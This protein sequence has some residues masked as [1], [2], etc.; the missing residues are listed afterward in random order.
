MTIK[1]HNKRVFLSISRKLNNTNWTLK[2][3]KKSV[4]LTSSFI[5]HISIQFDCIK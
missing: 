3:K 5:N 4:N 2:Y 1:N